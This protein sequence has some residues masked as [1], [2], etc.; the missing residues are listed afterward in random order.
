VFGTGGEKTDTPA[1]ERSFDKLTEGRDEHF[2]VRIRFKER[3][4]EQFEYFQSIAAYR[5]PFFSS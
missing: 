3:I 4:G 1:A 5:N 2:A